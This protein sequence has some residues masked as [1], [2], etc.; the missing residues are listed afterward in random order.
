MNLIKRILRQVRVRPY[1]DGRSLTTEKAESEDSA[2]KYMEERRR[3]A[4]RKMR[5]YASCKVISMVRIEGFVKPQNGMRVG[6]IV[7][8]VSD[9]EPYEIDASAAREGRSFWEQPALGGIMLTGW[10]F[11][12]SCSV[13][14]TYHLALPL[15]AHDGYVFAKEIT[16]VVNG[17]LVDC[18][19]EPAWNGER[20]RECEEG[21]YRN[22][23]EGRLDCL[24]VGWT[25]KHTCVGQY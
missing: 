7:M 1:G 6:D 4:A 15:R 12:E 22:R 25:T 20:I 14:E 18:T 3:E 5:Y 9:Q 11:P 13:G 17:E 8:S 21:F 24:V 2:W 19:E 10:E 23:E 16:L